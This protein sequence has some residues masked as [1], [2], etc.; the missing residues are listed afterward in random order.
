MVHSSRSGTLG[1]YRAMQILGYNTYHMYECCAVNGL[2]HMEILGEAIV[3]QH[4]RLSGIKRFTRDD[5]EKW[6]ANYDVSFHLVD[7]RLSPN[8]IL[9][10]RSTELTNC[11]SA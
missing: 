11:N 4:N 1:L 7:P 5:F 8:P 10:L 9:F 2:P 6:F 3:A